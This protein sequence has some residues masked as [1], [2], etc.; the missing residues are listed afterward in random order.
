VV[1]HP[2][3]LNPVDQHRFISFFQRLV[4]T[5][6]ESD[7][8]E[9]HPI[10]ALR[11]REGALGVIH[12]RHVDGVSVAGQAHK[13]PAVVRVLLHH[14][15]P[16]HLGVELFSSDHIPHPQGAVANPLQLDRHGDLTPWK[17]LHRQR[18]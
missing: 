18:I 14:L 15:E 16:K 6:F 10:V 5:Y 7:V 3:Y 12:R 2:L 1:H 11:R 9:T 13:D 17:L 8:D 4:A